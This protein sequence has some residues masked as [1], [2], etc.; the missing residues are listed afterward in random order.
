MATNFPTGLD[1]IYDPVITDTLSSMNHHVIHTTANDAI[2]ALEA[3]VGING[4]LVA[5]SLDWLVNSGRLRAR[6]TID[7]TNAT[8]TMANLADMSVAVLAGEEYTGRL[9][10]YANDSVAA[11]GLAF[12]FA[13]GTCSITSFE[14]AFAATPPG[15]GLALGTL[16]STALATA[17]TATTAT[18]G[19]ACYVIEFS[20]VVNVPG[21][22]I[23]RFAQASHTT[24]AATVRLGSYLWLELSPN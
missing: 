18:T 13:G 1:S 3:K 5:T 4:S 2:A 12:D 11:E 15:S 16:T 8:V 17:L 9:V 10:V 24:G 21:T 19:D 20:F 6:N 7:R 14:A 22:F 23:P